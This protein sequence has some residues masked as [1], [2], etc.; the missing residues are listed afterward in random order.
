ML[1]YRL[2]HQLHACLDMR[3][4]ATFTSALA[5][6]GLCYCHAFYITEE[7]SEDDTEL[8]QNAV[9]KCQSERSQGM[10]HTHLSGAA[11]SI[12]DFPRPIKTAGLNRDS[13]LYGLKP[14]HL[15]VHL[16]ISRTFQSR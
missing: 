11:L 12:S 4:F 3:D 2:V 14:R 7:S 10:I 9:A 6:V 16:G 13:P 15:K 8:V 5:P 1:I